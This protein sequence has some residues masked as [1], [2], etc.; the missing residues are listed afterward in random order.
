MNNITSYLRKYVPQG[1]ILGSLLFIICVND[2]T[3]C[4]M[5]DKVV[6]YADHTLP[7]F[8]HQYVVEIKASIE[9][10]LSSACV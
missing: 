8:A 1:S 5:N 6:L 2:H 10:D 9:D 4:L 7:M 3:N